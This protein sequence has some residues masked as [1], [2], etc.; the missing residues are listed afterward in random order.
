MGTESGKSLLVGDNPFHGISHLSGDRARARGGEISKAEYAAELVLTSLKNGANGFMFS[1]SETTL[2]ALRIIS[3]KAL[4]RPI[5]LHAIVPYAY[6][7]VRL[8]THLGTLGLGRKLA[9]R[10]VRSGN[11]KAIASG[12]RGVVSMDPVSF[13]KAY[14]NYEK[15]RIMSSVGKRQKLTSILLHEVLT[16]MVV[17]LNLDWFVESYVRFLSGLG[18]KPGF[19]TRNF[20]YLVNKFREWNVDFS[21]IELVSSFNKVGFQMNPSKAKCEEALAEVPECNVIGMSMLA[22]GYLELSDAAEYIKSLP[23]LFGV[24]V[25]ISKQQQAFETFS[26]LRKEFTH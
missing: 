5:A 20:A 9:G 8:A 12:I 3:E 15:S 13:M 11:L 24:V 23:T 1:V 19:E 2:S 26:Y 14:L 7:Y 6:E 4:D 10:V 17:A 25:G 21:G 18:I 16:D 22:A